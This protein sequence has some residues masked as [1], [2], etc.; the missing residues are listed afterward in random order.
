[1]R[2]N[3]YVIKRGQ[4]SCAQPIVQRPKR[5]KYSGR[6]M[7][8]AERLCLLRVVSRH[9]AFQTLMSAPH[10]KAAMQA[11][12]E[13][14]SASLKGATNGSRGYTRF[15]YQLQLLAFIRNRSVFHSGRVV[16]RNPPFIISRSRKLTL[17]SP[18]ESASASAVKKTCFMSPRSR[19]LTLQS[20]L[21]S[22]PGSFAGGRRSRPGWSDSSGCTGVVCGFK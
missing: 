15:Y 6:V 20:P 11:V 10:P 21:K 9:Q 22:A 7:R 19:K 1:M 8:T 17:P 13:P 18:S 2:I 12:L 5:L 16:G 3:I 4:S 14:L